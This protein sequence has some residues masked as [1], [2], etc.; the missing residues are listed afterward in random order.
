LR[1]IEPDDYETTYRWRNDYELQK[2]TCGPMRYI[3]KEMEKNWA[4]SRS[5]D[6]SNN[7]YLAICSYETNEMIGWISINN[8]DYI[9]R[10]CCLG[11]IEIGDKEHQN[12][13]EYVESIKMVMEY[14]FD[15]L[16]MNKIY[17]SCLEEH[18]LSRAEPLA[19]FSK[20]EGIE[21]QS[22]YKDGKYHNKFN[23][24]LLKEDY[25]EHKA[26][27]DYDLKEIIKRMVRISKQIKTDNKYGTADLY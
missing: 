2:M 8:I 7:I 15:Q 27:G 25:L 1:L 23:F 3:S 12:G 10:K 26:V 9:N 16:N 14:A 17:S 19:F 5:K 13:F 4:L 22:I 11:G 6:N 24:G 20:V 21:R 18:L